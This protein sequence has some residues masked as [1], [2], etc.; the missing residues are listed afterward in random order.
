[1]KR[2]LHTHLN[3]LVPSIADRVRNKQSQQ[4]AAHDYHAKEREILEG[5]AV[6]AKDFRYKKA[7]MSGT[8]VEKTGPVSA[9]VQLDNGTVI[10][11]HQDHVRRRENDVAEEPVVGVTPSVTPG[12]TPVVLP[13]SNATSP[14]PGVSDQLEVPKSPSAAPTQT[15]VETSPLVT[16]PVRKRVRPGY[17]K[18]LVTL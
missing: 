2:R 16:R 10:R 14:T 18:D 12:V 13:E 17:L 15:P 7:W 6:Y 5:Q 11:R 1:M 8:V 3:Q 4:K 9:R